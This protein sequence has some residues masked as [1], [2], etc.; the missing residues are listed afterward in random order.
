MTGHEPVTLSAAKNLSTHLIPRSII[1]ITSSKTLHSGWLIN[2]VVFPVGCE[3]YMPLAIIYVKTDGN[4]AGQCTEQA[5]IN[6]TGINIF[7]G[8][9]ANYTHDLPGARIDSRPVHGKVHILNGRVA[10]MRGIGKGGEVYII[11]YRR[12]CSGGSNPDTAGFYGHGYHKLHHGKS[13][14]KNNDYSHERKHEILACCQGREI[15][16]PGL[17][18]LRFERHFI[19]IWSF[20]AGGQTQCFGAG[21]KEVTQF[22]N[23]RRIRH[24][25]APFPLAD[26]IVTHSQLFCD[27][28]A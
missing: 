7:T 25:F 8:W 28:F 4:G 26:G 20:C 27:I 2:Q 16:C 18:C 11:S 22:L 13:Y 10:L 24:M 14:R 5:Q 15:Y 1:L 3:V 19:Q 23:M 21:I 6:V 17:M 12:I 9:N